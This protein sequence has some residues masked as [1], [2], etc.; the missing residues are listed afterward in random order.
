MRKFCW[1]CLPA[2]LLLLPFNSAYPAEPGSSSGVDVKAIE[3][4]VSPCQNFY[5]YACGTWRKDNPIPSDQARW[6]RFNQLAEQNLKIERD[7]LEKAANP[8]AK[9]TAVE[10]KIGDY[11]ASCMDDAAIEAKGIEPIQST[12][13]SIAKL[14]SKTDL[15]GEIARLQHTGVRAFFVFG[16]RPDAKNSNEQIAGVSQ[17]GLGLPDRDYYLRNDPRS[18]ELRKQYQQTI[19]AMFELLAK[20]QGRDAPDV[21]AKVQTVMSMETALAKVAMDRVAI[22]NPDNTYHK[23][24]V[25]QLESLT[26]DLAWSQFFKDTGLPPIK[27]LNVGMP[28]FMKGLHSL[29]DSASLSDIQTYLTWHVLLADA[30]VL[31]KAFR[32]ANWDFFQH[33]LAGVKEQPARWKQCV[34]A[35]DRALGEALGQ[36]FVEAAFSGASKDK[37]LQLV[38]EIEKEMAADIKSATWMSPATKDQALTKLQLV[39]NKIGY[40]EKWRDYS[41]VSIVRGDYFGDSKRA[42]EFGIER[43]LAKLGKPV[44]KTEWGMTPPTVN[45][46]YSPPENNIN[47]PAG[48]LQPPFYNPKADDAVNYGAIGVVIGHELTHGFDDQGRRYDGSGNLRDWWTPEDAKN[49]QTRADCVVKEYGGF[50]PVEGVNLNGKLTLGENAADNGGIHLAYAALM[51][52]LAGKVLPKKDGYTPQQQFFL[53]YAQIWCENATEASSRL[54]AQTDPHSPGQFRVNGVLQNLPEFQEAF[55]CKAGDAMVSADPCRVW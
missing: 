54:R 52:S 4:D 14:F 27:T 6:S 2:V 25:D 37:A 38:G 21:D 18:V 44:D 48:I 53:G 39:S 50:S 55:S 9:R 23:M 42:V 35:T 16:V 24:T 51:D 33:T 28:E 32:D 7:I 19:R 31:P 36:K 46:Y 15:T 13:D 5:Q 47:F 30:P 12:L 20:A 10:Q 11:Y 1:Q 49:F 22:R 3:T 29:I 41:S 40:P 17:G 26:P 45:A 8:S 43:N 34:Q